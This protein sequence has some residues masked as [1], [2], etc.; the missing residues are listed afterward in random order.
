MEKNYTPL[1]V[2]IPVHNSEKTLEKVLE[3]LRAELRVED[4]LIAV[5]DRSTD[6][7]GELALRLGA[8]VLTSSGS[9]GAAGAR[10]TGAQAAKGEWV[11]FVDSDA[12]APAG[13][14]EKLQRRID[15]GSAAVQ[16]TYSPVAAGCNAATFYKNFYYY[17]TFTRRIGSDHI[18]GCGTF[19]FAVKNSVFQGLA[20]FDDRIPGAT[21][22]DADFAARLVGSG[23]SILIATEIEIFHLREYTF[24]ELMRYE[25]NM[26][27]SKV[28]Y[29]LRRSSDH[30][31][32]SFSMATPLEMLP[33]LSG[34]VSVWFI[35][36]GLSVYV[37]GWQSG[38]WL[39]AAGLLILTA[40]HA[41]FWFASVKEGGKRG[42]IASLMTLPD[43]TLI[44][45]AVLSGFMV[46]IAGR[47]Y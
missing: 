29:L 21:V 14:R 33:V 34:A 41:G 18:T 10:N 17:Y 6:G 19:F 36:F 38:I 27:K 45:P 23:E 47:K 37:A 30:A 8:V 32:P 24:P 12:V 7:S 26:M 13:W 35:P 16:A 3:P 28:L 22:E 42:F 15:Q 11:L 4:E 31:I 25:W 20:G 2:V 1:T 46:Y 39:A 9:P 40:G 43:L 5:D 44:V